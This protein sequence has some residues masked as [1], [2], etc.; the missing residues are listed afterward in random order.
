MTAEQY[1]YLKNEIFNITSRISYNI[2]KL[3]ARWIDRK[4]HT[5]DVTHDRDLKNLNDI[6]DAYCELSYI[7][8]KYIDDN[9]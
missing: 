3:D 9:I 5:D 4:I 6:Y 8:K 2:G 7:V 1:S